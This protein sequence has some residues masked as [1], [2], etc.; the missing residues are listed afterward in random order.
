[1]KKI[2]LLLVL[3]L[4]LS[5]FTVA[6]APKAPATP[7]TPAA[8]PAEPA[9]P[10][11]PPA[12]PSEPTELILSTWGFNEE[13]LRKNIF[14]PFEEAN[15]VKIILE[16]GNNADR[17]NKI[18]LGSS[19]IDVVQI[20]EGFAIQAIA[21]GLFEEID[22]SNIPNIENLYDVAKAPFGEKYGPAYTVGRYGIMYDSAQVDAPIESW[23]D[24][25][26]DS[27][28][29][30]VLI[31][32]ITTTAGPFMPFIVADL[33]GLDVKNDSDA[34]FAKIKALNPNLVKIYTKSSEVVNMFS[35]GE[36]S[37]VAGQDF[38]FGQVKEAVP[39]AVWLDPKEG[40]YAVVN[41]INVVKGSKNK[42]LAEKFIDWIISEEVQKANALDK[43]DSPANKNVVLTEAEAAGLTYGADVINKLVAVDWEY[44]NSVNKEWID[45]WNREVS[46]GN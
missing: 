29:K 5:V 13:L 22:R 26:D 44:I 27:L 7:P 35:Q 18:R 46:S 1:M 28:E 20:A 45:K 15:N 8:P 34:I 4:M 32:D 43:V 36:V 25:W 24:L 39:T 19:N 42:E 16:V 10:V 33:E 9:A 37:V 40:A 23:G 38:S 6:C 31:P 30:Q 12:T 41:T 17:L 3:V 21:E 14:T 2:S 11:T